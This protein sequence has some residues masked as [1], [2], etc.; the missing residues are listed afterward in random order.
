MT[1]ATGRKI[2]A[3][4]HDATLRQMIED[5]AVELEAE[6]IWALEKDHI[7]KQVAEMRPLAILVHLSLMEEVKPIIQGLKASPA[8][9][10]VPVIAF[11]YHSDEEIIRKAAVTIYQDWYFNARDMLTLD[12]RP[13]LAGMIRN[14]LEETEADSQELLDHCAQPMTPLVKKGL[15]EFNAGEYYE[16]HETLEAAWMAETTPVRDMYRGILQVA[17]AYYQIQ[18]GNYNGAMKLF[19]RSIQ[20]LEPLP[21]RCQGIEIARFRAGALQARLAMEALGPERIGEFDQ[22]L[23]K[24]IIYEEQF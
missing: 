5:A 4:V 7:V 16:C 19:L 22:K 23:M 9:R 24:P 15:E 20:W 14:S 21:E 2:L 13:T 11:D 12:I 6:V 3:F 1:T 8:T 18:R 17:V 10:R